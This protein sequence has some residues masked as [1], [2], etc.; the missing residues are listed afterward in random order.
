MQ[1]TPAILPHSFDEMTE[2]LSRIEGLVNIVQID[3]CDGIFGREK[4]WIP[5]GN[6]HLQDI[7]AY[8]FDVMVNDWKTVIPAALAAGAMSIVAHVDSFAGDDM[9]TLISFMAPHGLSLG[10][11]VSNDKMIDFHIEKIREAQALYGD[12]YIQ[13]MGIRSI[14]EQGQVFDEEALVRIK[15]LK[16]I[17]PDMKVQV[18]GG[19]IP[20][21][22]RRVQE[23]GAD[24]VVVGSYV[25]GEH[26]AG[27]ALRTLCTT[28]DS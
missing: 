22:A 28:L 6:V 18:D 21:T 23:A 27:E 14:G 11:A 10:I 3:V 8:E 4:T 17:F 25:F 13:V 16:Q 2:K 5:D 24:G 12:L 19:M 26:D 20:E 15:A 9:E 1:I 7:A